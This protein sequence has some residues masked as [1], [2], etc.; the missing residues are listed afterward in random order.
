MAEEGGDTGGLASATD[1]EFSS[2]GQP[3][4]VQGHEHEEPAPHNHS[5]KSTFDAHVS[6]TQTPM[7]T[8]NRGSK[9]VN[10]FDEY[11]VS[12]YTFSC[13]L[14]VFFFLESSNWYCRLGSHCLEWMAKSLKSA[15]E[16]A[17]C[18]PYSKTC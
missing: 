13:S 11:F 3:Q 10:D 1:H 18:F 4:P 15:G 5:R 12:P 16:R 14:R 6:G 7:S 2:H 9:H 17:G 8:V